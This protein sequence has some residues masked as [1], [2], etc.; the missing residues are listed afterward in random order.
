MS[1]QTVIPPSKRGFF[2][3]K[4]PHKSVVAT[5]VLSLFLG[6][7][8]LHRFYLG[9]PLSGAVM[10]VLSLITAFLIVSGLNRMETLDPNGMLAVVSGA[11]GLGMIVSAWAFV[12][13]LIIL[14]GVFNTPSEPNEVR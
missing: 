13:L 12:D 5:V 4:N 8:G 6:G 14:V 2:Y 7:L 9:K 3:L 1:D 10:L 11:L